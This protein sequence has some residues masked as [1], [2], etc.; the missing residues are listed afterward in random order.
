M[1][2]AQQLPLSCLVLALLA[3]GA[4]A[5]STPFA[6]RLLSGAG[7]ESVQTA[8]SSG[9]AFTAGSA[10]TSASG[11][12]QYALAGGSGS[13][14]PAATFLSLSASAASL[15]TAATVTATFMGNG[16][17]TTAAATYASGGPLAHAGWLGGGLVG[18]RATAS[19]AAVLGKLT[20]DGAGG[21]SEATNLAVTSACANSWVAAAPV[22]LDPIGGIM[23]FVCGQDGAA[24]VVA[25]NTTSGAVINTTSVAGISGVISALALSPVTGALSAM[26]LRANA[27]SGA[28]TVSAGKLQGLGSTPAL[29]GGGASP[30]AGTWDVAPPAGWTAAGMA[31]VTF[32]DSMFWVSANSAGSSETLMAANGGAAS[33]SPAGL[34]TALTPINAVASSSPPSPPPPSPPPPS[35]P[36]AP[37]PSPKPPPPTTT[38]FAVYAGVSLAGVTEAAFQSDS[39]RSAFVTA[40]ASSLGVPPTSVAITSVSTVAGTG[41]RLAQSA[42]QVNYQVRAL[43][44][45]A[46]S[47]A[48]IDPLLRRSLC[49]APPRRLA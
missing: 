42:L 29:G 23:Y 43:R 24:Q 45:A 27:S 4:A 32:S 22:A 25:L 31:G 15:S 28:V 3:G 47:I 44:A 33:G 26:A 5:Q 17:S 35:P 16:S 30:W 20:P 13:A 34:I 39:V 10:L 9:G 46:G 19:G 36:P 38:V 8:S 14:A 21:V 48:P 41:R 11:S 6:F 37:P 12:W 18:L 40:T 2:P 1:W 49:Q 7:V